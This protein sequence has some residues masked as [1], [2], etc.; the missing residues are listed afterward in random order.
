M[1]EHS[2]IAIY[3]LILRAERAAAAAPDRVRLVVAVVRQQLLEAEVPA[4]APNFAELAT[5]TQLRVHPVG[6]GRHFAHG[7]DDQLL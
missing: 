6:V 1:A 7:S 3:D 2:F 5:C 4:A